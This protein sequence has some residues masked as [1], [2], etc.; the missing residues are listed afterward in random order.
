MDTNEQPLDPRRREAHPERI[1][2]GGET[3]IRNDVLAREL[4]ESERSLNRG[5]KRGSPYRFFGGI[6]Y[7]PERLHAEFIMRTIQVRQPPSK[8]TQKKIRK[9]TADSRALAGRRTSAPPR[10]RRARPRA[11]TDLAVD[12][13]PR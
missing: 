5:D 8:Q 2:V 12:E 10:R 7:R 13:A 9:R 6:K 4:G 11:N 3:F 1:S